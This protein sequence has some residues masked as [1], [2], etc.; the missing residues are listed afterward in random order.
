VIFEPAKNGK[1][2]EEAVFAVPEVAP[3]AAELI[4]IKADW[5]LAE[6]VIEPAPVAREMRGP[7][8]KMIVPVLVAEGVPNAAT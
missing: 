5:L 4:D 8:D 3:P 6:I 1:A 2:V 7:A